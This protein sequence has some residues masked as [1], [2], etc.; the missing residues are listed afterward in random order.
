ML[1][2]DANP[3]DALVAALAEIDR[4]VA[5]AGWGAPARLFALVRTDEL[6]AAEPT[7]VGQVSAGSPDSLSSIE[8]DGFHAG[9]DVE[10]ALDAI[11][12]PD[13]VAG[14][15]LTLE[16]VFLPADVE[17]EIPADPEEAA[18]F[19]AAHPRRQ[20]VR[21]V[22]GALRDGTHHGL[23]RLLD[24]PEDLLGGVDLVPAL[25][26]ALAR[27]LQTVTPEPGR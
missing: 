11:M 20:D 9:D 27:T 24:H 13:T 6:L 12:W 14:A 22:V 5:D 8:Q 15:A 26:S 1:S 10:A 7:L 23:A 16:R 4:F 17:D 18:R 3:S 2:D 21:V 25:E 19:V